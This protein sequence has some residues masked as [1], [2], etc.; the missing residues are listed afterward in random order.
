M[1]QLFTVPTLILFVVGVPLKWLKRIPPSNFARLVH[2]P[3]C[4]RVLLAVFLLT[5]IARGMDAAPVTFEFKGVWRDPVLVNGP[6]QPGNTFKGR[7][8]Y[9]PNAAVIS[10]HRNG[11]LSGEVTDYVLN[12]GTAGIELDVTTPSGIVSFRS[13][14]LS[15]QAEVMNNFSDGA[16][17]PT[18]RFF[19]QSFQTALFP[20]VYD[21]S[22]KRFDIDIID[23]DLN[24]VGSAALPVNLKI[25]LNGYA[26]VGIQGGSAPPTLDYSAAGTLQ[27][28]TVNLPSTNLDN[29]VTFEPMSSTVRTS[30]DTSGCP[31]GFAAKF[32][33]TA[34]LSVKTTSPSISNL[35]VSIATLTNGNLVQNADGGPGGTGSVLSIAK[36]GQYSD[37]ILSPNP[38]EFVD[39][40]FTLCL[41]TAAPF[42]FFV[43][44]LGNTQ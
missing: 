23:Y 33:F 41:K 37:G 26:L 25:P 42:V 1:K 28:L 24:L 18:D 17:P 4:H 34:R 8:F 22:F 6:V 38:A 40:P 29:L 16:A 3:T 32:S 11:G 35:V 14:S 15:M 9:D 21:R 13:D 31:S 12:P 20:N 2:S 39:V 19:I 10:F 7:L 5:G 44:V 43:D 30:L 27:T 36:M